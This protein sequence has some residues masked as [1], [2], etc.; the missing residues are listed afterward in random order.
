MVAEF[1]ITKLD[2][3][4]T[5]DGSIRKRTLFFLLDDFVEMT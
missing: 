2:I 3:A 4:H 5:F 1:L